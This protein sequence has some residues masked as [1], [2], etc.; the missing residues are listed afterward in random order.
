[1]LVVPKTHNDH[2]LYSHHSSTGEFAGG[3]SPHAISSVLPMQKPLV[4]RAG[5]VS[6][7]HCRLLHG[8]DVNRSRNR[9]CLLVLEVIAND[10]WPLVPPTV[11]LSHFQ[12]MMMLADPS[13]LDGRQ[14]LAN[15]RIEAG[16]PI[17][18]PLPRRPSGSLYETQLLMEDQA[19]KPPEVQPRSRL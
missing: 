10:A 5:T 16:I 2:A 18:L 1:M 13:D 14:S 11:E 6:F 8:S 4:G 7:H 3:V 17:R 12:S 15:P 19:F 9:R